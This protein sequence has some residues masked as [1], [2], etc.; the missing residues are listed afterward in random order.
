ML[1]WKQQTQT[2][3]HLPPKEHVIWDKVHLSFSELP[4]HRIIE[5]CYRGIMDSI[6]QEM[7]QTTPFTLSPPAVR[8]PERRG[9]LLPPLPLSLLIELLLIAPPFSIWSAFHQ[10]WNHHRPLHLFEKAHLL[11][12]KWTS[13]GGARETQSKI[14]KML[15][16]LL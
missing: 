13:M 9:E 12:E 14:L 6:S 11:A 16:V 5:S 8:K 10:F 1:P 3:I 4:L 7:V 15:W 2:E